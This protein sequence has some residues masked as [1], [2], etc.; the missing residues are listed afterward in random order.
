VVGAGYT[1]DHP[2]GDYATIVKLFRVAM[3]AVVVV[4][5]MFKTERD[6]HC[7][8]WRQ[9]GDEEATPG[10]LVPLGVCGF[11]GDQLAGLRPGRGWQSPERFFALVSGGGDRGTGYQDLVSA[12]GQGRLATVNLA[13]GGDDL[14]GGI[15]AD[16][17]LRARAWALLTTPPPH[18]L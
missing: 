14:D 3:L 4:S 8:Q 17:D 18:M 5:A 6:T 2:T 1:I 12:T 11:G 10:A 15:R 13:A 7:R 16:R 9:R